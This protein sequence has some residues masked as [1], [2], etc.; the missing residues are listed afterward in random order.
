ML[1]RNRVMLSEIFTSIS[2]IIPDPIAALSR[3]LLRALEIKTIKNARPKSLGALL[4]LFISLDML[5]GKFVEK[6]VID[7]IYIFTYILNC[8]QVN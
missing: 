6:S 5:S 3:I 7:K 2:G 1:I 4:S 8:R